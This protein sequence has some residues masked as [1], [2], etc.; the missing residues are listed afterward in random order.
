MILTDAGV[1]ETPDLLRTAEEQLLPDGGKGQVLWCGRAATALYW[2]YC[3]A[4]GAD[5]ATEAPEVILP[6]MACATPANTAIL[7]GFRPRFADNDPATGLITPEALDA[8]WTPRTRAVL[9][10]HLFGQTGDLGAMARWCRERKVVLIED[11]AQALGARM[12]DGRVVGSVGDMSV[13]SFSP[14]K[15][16]GCG[17]GA[18][19]VRDEGLT[20]RLRTLLADY[21]PGPTLDPSMRDLLALSYRNLHH[22]LVALKRLRAVDDISAPFL[23]L[24][25]AYAGLYLLPL[26]DPGALAAAW[27]D[28]TDSLRRRFDKAELYESL[29]QGRGPWTLLAGWRESGVC[30]RYSMLFHDPERLVGF[31]DAVRDDGFHVS[32]LY[33]DLSTFFRPEDLCPGADQFARGILNLWVDDSVDVDYVGRCCQSLKRHASVLNTKGRPVRD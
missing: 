27:P 15:F 30:W 12:P 14:G 24:Q 23:Q 21:R 6:A 33:W 22:S 25:P 18:L 16:L 31:C 28:L 10:I 8:R 3:A 13:Y 7:A 5:G 2:S 9:F 20:Q 1:S 32:N 29:L 4:K 26:R 19:L 11:N 17:G